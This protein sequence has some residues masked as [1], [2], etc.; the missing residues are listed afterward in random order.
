MLRLF[1][2]LFLLSTLNACQSPGPRSSAYLYPTALLGMPE[3][4]Q[5][6]A[7]EYFQF[8]QDQSP[9]WR[10]DLG[11]SG[12]FEWNDISQEANEAQLKFYQELRQKLQAIP[13]HQ[14]DVKSAI[15]YR[16]LQA[17]LNFK[18]LTASFSSYQDAYLQARWDALVVN[19]LIYH[20]PISSVSDAQDYIK[21]LKA[22]PSLFKRW[23]ENIKAAES[24]G[25][26]ANQFTYNK[27]KENIQ[28]LRKSSPTGEAPAVF[29]E[30]LSSK[31]NNLGLYRNTRMILESQAKSALEKT[32]DAYRDLEKFIADI[33]KNAPKKNSLRNVDEGLHYYQILLNW[34]SASDMDAN[35][36]AQLGLSEINRIQHDIKKLIPKLGYEGDDYT[37]FIK[38]MNA[39]SIH[40]KTDNTGR[41]ELIQYQQDLL[42]N[43]SLDL[44]A[45]FAY[46]PKTSLAVVPILTQQNSKIAFYQAPALFGNR[47]GLY[48][49]NLNKMVSL[50]QYSLP[51]I[52]FR[53]AIGPHLQAAS[54]IE[55]ENQSGYLRTRKNPTF[56]KGWALYSANLGREMGSYKTPE[57]EYGSLMHE[58]ILTCALVLDTGL[59]SGTLNIEEAKQF[60]LKN[61]ALNAQESQQLIE[62]YLTY[63]AQAA[64]YKMGELRIL[65]LRQQMQDKLGVRFNL[66]QFHQAL[67][68][69][70]A[71]PFQAID[72]WLAYWANQELK[73]AK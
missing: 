72:L 6:L 20:H 56:E 17:E 27:V 1:F 57:E 23:Q 45:Y 11:I 42:N 59:N 40:F 47:P 43:L 71:L 28:E 46:L 38:A 68:S 66:A 55:Q 24:Q 21:R 4:V 44:P 65:S 8:E 12:Q 22:I 41:A 30:D 70:G 63:P 64:A 32:N 31:L 33:S 26:L 10:S 29:W 61:T 14:L 69:Q 35:T 58:L 15:T 36:M 73:N 62:S 2:V 3:Q 54:I 16:S 52:A 18:L 39:K 25:L 51:A 7:A 53:E 9:V 48:F 50:P 5:A 34:Y 60:L 19:T 37:D 67:L 49:I 13:E